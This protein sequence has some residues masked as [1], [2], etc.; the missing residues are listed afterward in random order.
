MALNGFLPGCCS[1]LFQMADTGSHCYSIYFPH[2]MHTKP[3]NCPAYIRKIRKL[4]ADIVVR[5]AKEAAVFMPSCND[6]EIGA[7]SVYFSFILAGCRHPERVYAGCPRH[8]AS[9]FL[10]PAFITIT[11]AAPPLHQVL[12]GN[13]RQDDFRVNGLLIHLRAKRERI[14]HQVVDQTR[15]PV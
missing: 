11:H 7:A 10:H 9:V 5:Y 6:M 2:R 15:V 12:A 13:S 1:S 4:T 3:S 14:R 8:N